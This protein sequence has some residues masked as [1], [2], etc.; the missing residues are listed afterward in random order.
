MYETVFLE[1]IG[2]SLVG[3]G[4]SSIVNLFIPEDIVNWQTIVFPPTI[5]SAI[6]CIAKAVENGY[7]EDAVDD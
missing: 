6:Y 5:M 2:L 7:G 4:L 1:F 3:I